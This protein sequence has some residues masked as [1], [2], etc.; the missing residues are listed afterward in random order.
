MNPKN[1]TESKDKQEKDE[2]SDD[3]E[4]NELKRCQLDVVRATANL[5]YIPPKLALRI[6]FNPGFI[7]L[8]N[9][10]NNDQKVDYEALTDLV[11][12]GAANEKKDK[13]K[14]L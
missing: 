6:R 10:T 12:K 11:K 7:K 13:I 5:A 4:I 8:Y 2:K 14:T 9:E 1:G 3:H